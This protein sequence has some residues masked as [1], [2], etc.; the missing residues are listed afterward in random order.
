MI[1]DL[2]IEE[3][4]QILNIPDESP[5]PCDKGQWVQWLVSQV[6]N[7]KVKITGKVNDARRLIAYIVILD[8]II[9]PL[10]DNIVALHIWTMDH[11]DTHELAQVFI[12]WGRKIGAKR[13]LAS[14]SLGHPDKYMEVFGG[15]KVASVFEWSFE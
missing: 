2:T 10:F 15:K 14:I 9:L 12:D 13:G 7:P 8:N 11:R 4:T 6:E 5:L 3:I 1:K